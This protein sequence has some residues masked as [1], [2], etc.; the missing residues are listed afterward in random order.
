M[1]TTQVGL[2]LIIFGD[3]ADTDL[4]DVL[5]EVKAAGYD[6]FESGPVASAGRQRQV[7]S[8]MQD[9]GLRYVGAHTSISRISDSSEA[10]ALAARVRE[11]GGGF[12]I[13]S[14]RYDSLDGYREG[15]AILTRAAER[16][17]E[18]GVT[19][20]YHNH[21]WELEETDGQVPIHL[22]MEAT[23]PDLVKL[24]PDIYWL[25]VGG[26]HPADF[27]A[28]YQGRCPCVHLK[29]GLAGDQVREFRELGR[30]NVDV[31]A[32]LEAALA[33]SPNW[34]VVE[35]DTTKGEPAESIRISRD[36]LR[37]LGV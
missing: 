12:I 1:S 34:I 23:D 17:R 21:F 8:A 10:A 4:Q 29:D 27:L 35:Q 22:M 5:R 6:G 36:Y 18:A 19:L 26:E 14:A 13:V 16:G 31:R 20:C 24:C 32:A 7:H 33:C 3:R 2:Q 15:A 9:I 30:G 28:R 37:S 25:Y 11:L